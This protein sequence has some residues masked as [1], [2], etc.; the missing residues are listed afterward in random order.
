MGLWLL[1]SVA[2]S[3]K[4]NLLVAKIFWRIF[5]W[6]SVYE[7]MQQ[8]IKSCKSSS[9]I[10]IYFFLSLSTASWFCGHTDKFKKIIL[11]IWFWCCM[12]ILLSYLQIYLRPL[13][14]V[15]YLSFVL[16]EKVLFFLCKKEDNFGINNF[17]F[18]WP[19]FWLAYIA[20]RV[21]NWIHL[22]PISSNIFPHK[23]TFD[24]LFWTEIHQN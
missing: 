19:S 11:C 6:F 1:D 16:L 24:N 9:W 22:H 5:L 7:K 21:F 8:Y 20:R 4:K 23:I 18:F 14:N 3:I 15:W 2:Y 13:K 12:K 17:F 10:I